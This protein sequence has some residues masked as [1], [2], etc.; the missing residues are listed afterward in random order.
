MKDLK[1]YIMFCVLFLGF[2]SALCFLDRVHERYV[3][4]KISQIEMGV[5]NG[6]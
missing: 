3:R 2:V 4:L 6:K 1:L 5:T